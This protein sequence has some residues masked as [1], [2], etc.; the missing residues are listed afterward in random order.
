MKKV[1]YGIDAPRVVLNLGLFGFAALVIAIVAPDFRLGQFLFPHKSFYYPAAFLL[2]E[3]A[4]MVDYSVRGKFRHRDKMLKMIQWRGDE[5]VL[6][7]GTGRGLLLIGAAK[8]LT[9]GRAIGIDIWSK[10][11]LSDNRLERAQANLE[12]EGVADRCELRNEAA[13][14]M[15]FKNATFDVVLSNQCLHNIADNKE[16]N[17]ACAEIARVLKP[18]GKI[19]LSDF[20]NEL[21]Y[22]KEFRKAGLK[23]E[24]RGLHPFLR[25]IYAEKPATSQ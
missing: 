24:L 8:H 21:D 12:I 5:Q 25:I 9:T 17:Q 14:N 16:R 6:D 15:S 11:D 19:V 3:V 13:Q 22:I 7:V 1:S 2:A 23:V 20:I 10:K 18:D 4:L